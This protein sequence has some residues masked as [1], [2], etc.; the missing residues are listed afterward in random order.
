MKKKKSARARIPVCHSCNST[1]QK[2]C[3][4]ICI[5]VYIQTY[6]RIVYTYIDTYTLDMLAHI[7]CNMHVYRHICIVYI[8]TYTL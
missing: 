8:D 2:I 6:I 4:C 3:T 5:C 1:R 7:H